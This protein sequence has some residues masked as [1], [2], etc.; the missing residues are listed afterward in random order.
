[1]KK[2][3]HIFTGVNVAALCLY[4]LFVRRIRVQIQ[5]EERSSEIGDGFNY[6]FT[7]F[8]VLVAAVVW[9]GVWA[10]VA[11]DRVDRRRC[12]LAV[13]WLACMAVWAATYL[14]LPHLG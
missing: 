10:L 14:L 9:N 2:A 13:C 1:M 8:P 11:L 12:G 6:L 4:V 7:A 5:M 3:S